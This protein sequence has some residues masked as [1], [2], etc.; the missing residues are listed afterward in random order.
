METALDWMLGES[1]AR[2]ESLLDDVTHIHEVILKVNYNNDSYHFEC[3]LYA[4]HCALCFV[5]I[6]HV[7]LKKSL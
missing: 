2:L 3:L 7:T 4:W 5:H 1:G 6:S